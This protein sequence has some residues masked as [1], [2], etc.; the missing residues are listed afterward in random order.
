MGMLWDQRC[1]GTGDAASMDF[2]PLPAGDGSHL[3]P[4]SPEP[5]ILP[6]PPSTPLVTNVTKSSV[7]LTWKGSE[8]SGGTAVTYIVEAFRYPTDLLSR[9]RGDVVAWCD[10]AMGH[11]CAPAARP[12]VAHG[13]QWQPTWRVRLTQYKAS[14]LTPCTSSWCGHSTPMGSVIPVASQSPSALK[15]RP[16]RGAKRRSILGAPACPHTQLPPLFRGHQPHTTDA[17]RAGTCGCAPAG[18]RGAA[19]R[20]RAPRLD[21]ERGDKAGGR[22]RGAAPP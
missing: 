21:R 6:G 3:S 18:A 19:A 2:V 1:C 22:G 5:G 8:Q 13:R 12:W 4:P 14:S 16:S 7:T 17:P 15:V 20:C 9:F 10:L 11:L